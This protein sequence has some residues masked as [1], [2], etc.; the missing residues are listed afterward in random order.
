MRTVGEIENL[1]LLW[2]VRDQ[3]GSDLLGQLR[4]KGQRASI[5]GKSMAKKRVASFGTWSSPITADVVV[6]S[7]VSVLEP[8]VED[9]DVY[10]IEERSLERGRNVIVRKTGGTICDVTQGPFNARSQVHSYGGGAYAVHG[11]VVYFVN[12]SDNQI[13]RHIACGPAEKITSSPSCLYADLCV[14]PKHNRLI[15]IREERPNGD[16]INA[17]NRLVAV[18]IG[19]GNETILDSSSDFYSSPA[20]TRD[21]TKL[22]WLSWNHPNM[23]WIY[24]QLNVADF[25]AAGALTNKRLVSVPD[26][27]AASIF[28]PQWSPD[29]RLYFISDHSDFWNLYRWNGSSIENILPRN[30]DF[31]VPQWRFGLSTYAFASNDTLI[32]S[33]TE[34]GSW[35]LGRLDNRTLTAS[36]YAA[37][38]ASISYVRAMGK[39]VVVRC[40]SSI[41]PPMIAAVDV[42]TGAISPLK[43]SIPETSFQQ[44]KGYFSKPQ[45]IQFPTRDGDVAHAF[46]Y[47]PYNPDWQAE[48]S[49]RPPLI[50]KSHG[51]P[52]ASANSGLDLS[53][54]FWTSRGFAVLDVNYRGS[55]GYGRKYRE[56][57]YGNWGV[58]DV[59]DCISGA[60][61][62][63]GCRD[64]DGNKLLITGGSSGGYTTLC[65]LTFHKVF[66]AGSSYYGIGDLAALATDTHKFELHY[67]DWL[68]EPYRPGSVRYH[69]R[70]PINFVERLSAPVIFFHGEED[71][72]VPLNQA[73]TM[74]TALKNRNV[75]TALLA[76]QG[77]KHGF[78]QSAHIRQSLESELLFYAMNVI[79]APFTS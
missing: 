5:L 48:S 33:F 46:Y 31:G 78:R 38:F 71:P 9:N 37:E 61:F 30:A 65:A 43:Y 49:E 26:N 52:T 59:V 17:I 13:Y 2:Q 76:F 32:Y 6:T 67:M 63:A 36:D 41:S 14:D 28:Q 60:Q 11:K 18:D 51:G 24:T 68:V 15:A 39:T 23:P 3:I 57:L 62:L 1:T 53:L 66:A 44:L 4:L 64:V 77:E 75:P 29:G 54:Q 8:W 50:V 19:T 35:Y 74:F 25:D 10:W 45:T 56:K 58:V 7:A 12:Y 42:D 34:N 20:L 22:A 16:R 70:S 47:R 73:E 55:S 69:E 27:K 40:S 72:V 79:R 21:G